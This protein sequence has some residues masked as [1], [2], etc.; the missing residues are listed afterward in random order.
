MSERELRPIR[1]DVVNNLDVIHDDGSMSSCKAEPFGKP[2][3]VTLTQEQL[4]QLLNGNSV[5]VII[6]DNA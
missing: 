6:E 4:Q 1:F 3:N 5:E 2:I